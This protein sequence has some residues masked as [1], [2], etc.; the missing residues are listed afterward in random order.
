MAEIISPEQAVQIQTE[1]IRQQ[2]ELQK[3]KQEA[4]FKKHEL[5]VIEELR[6][7]HQS[8]QLAKFKKDEE[9]VSEEKLRTAHSKPLSMKDF[10][11]RRT[12]EIAGSIGEQ[13]FVSLN[14][15]LEAPPSIHNQ[16]KGE[17][18]LAN[19]FE[20]KRDND[21]SLFVNDFIL[22][23][24]EIEGLDDTPN[25]YTKVLNKLRDRIGLTEEH[26]K[27]FVLN[28]IYLYLTGRDKYHDDDLVISIMRNKTR[29]RTKGS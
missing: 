20:L 19:V 8:Q 27:D 6:D 13:P 26:K 28:K 4:E 22:T 24:M 7:L 18:F 25:G 23:A 2:Q 12:D 9:R 14:I 11:R 15:D 21:K 5:S 10:V 29:H 16:V 3:Q 1:Q 17:T